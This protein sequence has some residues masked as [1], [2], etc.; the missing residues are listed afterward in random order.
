MLGQALDSWLFTGAMMISLLKSFVRLI[1]FHTV[2]VTGLAVGSTL[3]CF[4]LD[5]TTDMPISLLAA[6]IIFPISFGYAPAPRPLCGPKQR[7]TGSHHAIRINYAFQRRERCFITMASLK[8]SAIALYQC[9]RYAP[10]VWLCCM[11]CVS[12][13]SC[14]WLIKGSEASGIRKPPGRR[15]EGAERRWSAR[16]PTRAGERPS[17]LPVEKAKRRK[18]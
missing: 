5:L 6:A 8:S 9:H 7:R 18:R 4:Y 10:C 11:S 16:R 14:S 2:L 13:V 3:M 17:A 15:S 12:C 1:T